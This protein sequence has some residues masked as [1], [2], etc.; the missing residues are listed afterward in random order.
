MSKSGVL[1]GVLLG[2]AGTLL[3]LAILG[4]VIVY[5]GAYNVAATAGHTAFGRW[6]L[7]T[8]MRNSV[9]ARAAV[10]APSADLRVDLAA[11]GTEYKAMCQQCHGGPGAARADWAEGIVPRPPDLSHAAETWSSNEIFWIVKHGIKMSGMPSFGHDHSDATLWN[12]AAFVK[13]LPATTPEQYRAYG[14]ED[15][16]NGHSHSH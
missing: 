6:A 2:S 11:G 14:G 9:E 13:E 12:I 15:E 4:F 7:D 8:T 5:T 3:V 16:A 10:L 1:R